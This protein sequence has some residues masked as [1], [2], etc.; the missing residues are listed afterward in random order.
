MKILNV[1]ADHSKFTC[2][3]L[4]SERSPHFKD[5]ANWC[6]KHSSITHIA[7]TNKMAE[8]MLT[9]DI[10]I[11]APGSTSWERACLGLPNVLVPLAEN[12][13]EICQQ[14][15]ECGASL[16][17]DIT[18]IETKLLSSLNRLVNNWSVYSEANL[19][20]C[21]GLGTQ[22]VIEKILGNIR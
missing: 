10:A 11:G 20:L 6:A 17:V 19:R 18:E 4:L 2:T 1:I 16:T 7:F 8:M 14:L 5:V 9:H 15:V 3:V 12:Q 22:R 21:D 13:N